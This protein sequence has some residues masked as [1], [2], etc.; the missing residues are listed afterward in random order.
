MSEKHHKYVLCVTAA[1]E[2]PAYIENMGRQSELIGQEAEMKTEVAYRSSESG[3]RQ[4][5]M[6]RTLV[7]RVSRRW[8]PALSAFVA[9][10]R[11]ERMDELEHLHDIYS[12]D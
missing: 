4:K 1:T 8:T 12:L 6:F 3:K 2:L 9:T 7:I 5:R 10:V 11:A